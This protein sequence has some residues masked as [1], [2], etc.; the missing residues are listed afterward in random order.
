[1]PPPQ[2]D[3]PACADVVSE[4]DYTR[5]LIA[6]LRRN[7]AANK[8]IEVCG[9][10]WRQTFKRDKRILTGAEEHI[11]NILRSESQSSKRKTD[12]AE[13]YRKISSTIKR[14]GIY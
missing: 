14:L 12:P 9:Q 3:T 5:G 1:M 10:E 6:L 7:F 8:I 4:K 11:E 2:D 13:Q